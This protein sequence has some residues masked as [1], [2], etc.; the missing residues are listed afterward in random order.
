MTQNT[1]QASSAVAPSG[2]ELARQGLIKP[3]DAVWDAY[4][5]KWFN[6]TLHEMEAFGKE[7][8]LYF[9]VARP[10]SSPA[11]VLP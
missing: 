4:E 9:A 8:R 3:G 6:P 2:Y 5:Q 10:T 11:P 1:K 7:V